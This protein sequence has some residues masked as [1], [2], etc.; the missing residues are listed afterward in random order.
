MTLRAALF[1]KPAPGLCVPALP[2]QGQPCDPL[3]GQPH[4]GESIR[5]DPLPCIASLHG[6]PDGPYGD[7]RCTRRPHGPGARNTRPHVNT[8]P[9][10]LTVHEVNAQPSANPRGRA[11]PARGTTM[12]RFTFTAGDH[13]WTVG[14]DDT[15][16]SY[17]AQREPAYW[18]QPVAVPDHDDTLSS[19]ER[20]AAN[21]AVLNG[22]T[23]D[24]DQALAAHYGR[25]WHA[26]L[27][28]SPTL[29]AVERRSSE[30][31]QTLHAAI[32]GHPLPS[33]PPVDDL[34]P[35][36]P[37][38]TVLGDRY[39]EVRVME[40]LQTRLFAEHDVQLPDQV[41]HQL[42]MDR[43]RYLLESDLIPRRS[44][45][46][47]AN[48]PTPP[49]VPSALLSGALLDEAREAIRLAS[50][51]PGSGSRPS[52]PHTSGRPAQGIPPVISPRGARG[53]HVPSVSDRG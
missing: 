12:S 7:G 24:H 11:Q 23:R 44:A 19:A 8:D 25:D 36:D 53:E 30:L 17:F 2:I 40:D 33:F 41:A 46:T 32:H 1:N 16:A 22:F 26:R 27:A 50:Y 28:E 10:E 52:A 51:R 34:D 18:P 4:T 13:R 9:G 5:G 21:A 47:T 31:F 37:V 20:T 38:E 45:D 15:V 3:P 42:D 39:G 6:A 14:Y 35:D 49:T 43:R 29:Q 48:G